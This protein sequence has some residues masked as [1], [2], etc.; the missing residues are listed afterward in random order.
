VVVA[1]AVGAVL[2]VLSAAAARSAESMVE[3]QA[4]MIA[5]SYLGEILGKP[6]G[7]DPCHPG[8]A[9]S[10]MAAV[11][12]YDG[13]VDAG[14]RD[15]QGNA[16]AGLTAYTVGVVVTQSALGAVPAAQSQLV[17]VTVTGPAG[18]RVVLSGYRTQYP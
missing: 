6:F 16:V 5:Q 17:T 9:R 8:C 3:Q 7:V 4:A 2:A 12:D 14:V 11:G 18:E 13:L 1:I 10:Q 15:A